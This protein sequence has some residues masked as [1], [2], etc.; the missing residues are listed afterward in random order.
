M[1]SIGETGMGII[2][3]EPGSPAC[4]FDKRLAKNLNCCA[5]GT[6][7]TIGVLRHP[8]RRA[9][10][11]SRAFPNSFCPFDKRWLLLLHSLAFYREQT[12]DFRNCPIN[13]IKPVATLFEHRR[14]FDGAEGRRVRSSENHS[15][16]I[17][18]K[19]NPT[20]C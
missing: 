7:K 12:A 13:L 1:R 9:V 11:F 19:P 14:K 16:M 4:N 2:N 15:T 18:A 10:A 5:S 8:L 3:A 6:T 20:R 17:G